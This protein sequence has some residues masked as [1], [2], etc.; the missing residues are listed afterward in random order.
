MTECGYG[1]GG[2]SATERSALSLVASP[3]SNLSLSLAMSKSVAFI[4]GCS[5][6]GIGAAFCRKLLAKGYI[7]YATARSIQAMSELEHENARKLVVDVTD[8]ASVAAAIDTVYA[9]TEGIDLLISN[10]GFSH[11][12]PLLDTPFEEGM[13]VMQTNFFGLVRLVKNVVPRM[14]RRGHGTVVAI[15]SIL[16]ELSTPFQGFYNASKAAL[17]SYTE[18]LRMECKPLKVKVVLVA[19]GSIRSNISAKSAYTAP[20]DSFYKS[21]EK[22][23]K[24][25]MYQSQTADYGVMDTDQFAAAIIGDVASAN[26]SAY[27]SLGGF[28]TKMW[29][30]QWLKR[31]WAL[32]LIWNLSKAEPKAGTYGP[33]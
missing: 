13:R 22:Q 3:H 12:G 30:L 6:G 25:V 14:A 8:D 2:S 31:T 9:E 21:F 23:I 18:T 28:T 29:L 33:M 5:N 11:I 15:G 26:P 20:E 24:H 7:V 4:T 17:R 1:C 32:D 10:A 16:G 19:P 27:I